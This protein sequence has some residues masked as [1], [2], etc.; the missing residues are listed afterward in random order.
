ML[1]GRNGTSRGL[2]DSRRDGEGAVVDGGGVGMV[3]VG[4]EALMMVVIEGGRGGV[5]L[6]G[7]GR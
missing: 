5:I 3:E 2:D 1:R 4:V 6:R 7:R